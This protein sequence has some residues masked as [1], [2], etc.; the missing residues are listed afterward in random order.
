MRRF[1]IVPVYTIFTGCLFPIF[2]ISIP[3]IN[4]GYSYLTVRHET[5]TIIDK[6]RVN[7]GKNSYYFVS[8]KNHEV[9][10]VKDDVFQGKFRADDT[11][12][13]LKEENKYKVKVNGIRSRSTNLYPNILE[14][15][16]VTSEFASTR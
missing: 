5:I 10:T 3:A 7:N 6:D 2:V 8:T 14:A 13:Q 9:F 1:N 15:F 16:E 12:D 4:L 11:Y